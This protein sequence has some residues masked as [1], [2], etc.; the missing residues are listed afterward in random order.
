MAYAML[1]SAM[2]DYVSRLRSKTREADR[3]SASGWVASGEES[4]VS[5]TWCCY[6]VGLD[7]DAAR[8]RII[9]G[10]PF[11]SRRSHVRRAQV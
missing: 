4:P 7:P 3:E 8:E 1:E 2:A 5:F 6:A 9:A 10:I 11:Q